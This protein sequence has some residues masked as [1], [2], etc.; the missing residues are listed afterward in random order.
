MVPIASVL[1]GLTLESEPTVGVERMTSLTLFSLA[2]IVSA[3]ISRK[4]YWVALSIGGGTPIG[5]TFLASG[6]AVPTFYAAAIGA[7]VGLVVR[8]V[9]DTRDPDFARP[10]GFDGAAQL[11]LFTGWSIVIT[12]LAP[13]LFFGTI[14]FL[15][16][17]PDSRSSVPA[18]LT[19]SNLAQLVYLLLGVSVVFFLAGCRTLG[20]EVVGLGAFLVTVLSFWRYLHQLVGLPFPEGLFDNNTTYAFIETLPG[21]APRFRGILSEPSGLALSSLVTIT[22]AVAVAPQLRGWRRVGVLLIAAMAALMA[23]I[24]T[25]TT[26]V[27]VAVIVGVIAA[28]MF[29]R[30][31]FLGHG[32]PQITALL[33]VCAAMVVAVFA[34]PLLVQLV[35]EVVA[36]KFGT[37]SYTDRTVSDAR[38]YAILLEKFG[39]GVGLGS[40][41][42]SSF[43]A[44]LLSTVGIPGFILFAWAIVALVRP[45]LHSPTARPVLWTLLTVLVSKAVSSPDLADSSGI[46]YLCLGFLAWQGEQV[47][48]NERLSL[49]GAELSS[50]GRLRLSKASRSRGGSS[51]GQET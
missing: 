48:R 8:A 15:G 23:V 9:R 41:R 26:F 40:N 51:A 18:E 13:L 17:N 35:S 10:P 19:T 31:L 29:L 16:P 4:H 32:R 22:F 28:I 45:A 25:S 49:R 6:N 30:R 36:E 2:V 47:R 27:I 46:L 39:L 37:A 50:F 24:S 20:P 21:G 11:L 38:S 34:L 3:A 43:T 44:F 7:A 12:A 33:L 1:I 14:V 5:A 42:S